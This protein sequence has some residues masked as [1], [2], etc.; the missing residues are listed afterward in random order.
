MIF[1]I[2]IRTALYVTY[3]DLLVKVTAP[4]STYS[5][6]TRSGITNVANLIFREVILDRI[7]EVHLKLIVPSIVIYKPFLTT[8]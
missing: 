7:L 5:T 4:L 6:N 8:A 1:F 2:Y 3:W